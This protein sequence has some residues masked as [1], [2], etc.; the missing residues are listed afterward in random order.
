MLNF[1]MSKNIDCFIFSDDSAVV[2]EYVRLFSSVEFPSSSS[3]DLKG[4]RAKGRPFTVNV[5]GIVG[6]GK[7]T[8]LEFFK[9]RRN[10]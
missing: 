1:K 7:S 9:V 4:L 10:K 8:L 6:T 3:S 5:E 2:S